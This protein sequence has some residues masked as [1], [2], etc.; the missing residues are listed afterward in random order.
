[1]ADIIVTVDGADKL[2]SALRQ[3]PKKV[4]R[5]M[6][7]AGKEA[8]TD[9]IETTGLRKYPTQIVGTPVVW[10][11]EKQRRYV[12]AAIRRGEIEV[13]Y[14]RGG[15]R[16]ERYGTQYYIKSEGMDTAIGNRA[17]YAKW[18]TDSKYQSRAMSARGWLKLLDTA[19]AKQGAITKIY[20]EWVDKLLYDVGLI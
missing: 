20:Q 14:R 15:K 10:K 19:V 13:P 5:Y 6:K 3:W 11:S 4:E 12:M 1:M 17:S 7:G 16:S 18:L 8:A 2:A 9:I